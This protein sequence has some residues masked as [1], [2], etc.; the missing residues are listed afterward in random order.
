MCNV[1]AYPAFGFWSDAEGSNLARIAY[2]TTPLQPAGLRRASYI[3]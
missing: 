2:K 3:S 1:L